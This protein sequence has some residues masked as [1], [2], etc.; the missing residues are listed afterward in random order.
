MGI[1]DR[2]LDRLVSIK[3]N[4]SVCK[5]SGFSS[6]IDGDKI[7]IEDCS[8]VK[9]ISQSIKYLDSNIFPRYFNWDIS[10]LT[11][12]FITENKKA[13]DIGSYK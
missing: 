2:L 6:K 11:P 13:Y 3:E 10:E 5:G 9:Q 12:Q 1:H 8:C 7:I 4:C